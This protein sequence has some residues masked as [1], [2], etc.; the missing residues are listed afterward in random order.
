MSS[1]TLDKLPDS[2]GSGTSCAAQEQLL[3][4]VKTKI[5]EKAGICVQPRAAE[6]RDVCDSLRLAG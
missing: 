1:D 2:A 5:R 4:F 6:C 3:Y